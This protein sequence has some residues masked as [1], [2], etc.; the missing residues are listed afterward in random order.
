VEQNKKNELYL[1]TVKLSGYKTIRNSIVQFKPGFNLIIG[2]NGV[3]KT[4]FLT[5][6]YQVLSF[7]IKNLKEVSTS[8]LFKNGKTIEI[9]SKSSIDE[10]ILGSQKSERVALPEI[11]STLKIDGAEIEY[12]NEKKTI[13][14]DGEVINYLTTNDLFI[15]PTLIQHGIPLNGMTFIDKPYTFSVDGKMPDIPIFD[16]DNTPYFIKS[17]MGSLFFEFI[18]L[19]E[20]AEKKD[21]YSTEEKIRSAVD[22]AFKFTDAIRP[23]LNKYSP[24]EDFRFNENINIAID[25]E[26]SKTTVSNI[27]LEFKIGESWLPFANLSDGTKRMFYIISEV[28]IPAIHYFT[29][30]SIGN[31]TTP[32]R[33]IILIEEPELGVHPHQLYKIISFLKHES[34]KNQI[35][36]S[37]HSPQVLDISIP[38]EDLDRIAIAYEEKGEGT[39][40][41]KLDEDEKK[42]AKKYMEENYLSDYWIHSDLEFKYQW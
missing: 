8:L 3:G 30:V 17:L 24:I 41:R 10:H 37:T 6:L 15:M 33:R 13:H 7:N 9:S 31:T 42:K 22:R 4:N 32:T 14:G 19:D 23:A 12:S 38:Q 11:K 29:K 25:K 1:D 28:A 18:D 5:F 2:I 40:F 35:I 34:S 39:L 16:D 27:F 20:E 36:I 21:V 26:K